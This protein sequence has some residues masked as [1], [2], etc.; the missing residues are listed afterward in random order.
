NR[1][2]A[3]QRYTLSLHDALPILS[4]PVRAQ[5]LQGAPVAEVAFRLVRRLRHAKQHP[6]LVLGPSPPPSPCRRQCQR[7]LLSESRP[8]VFAR[9]EEHTSELQSRENLVCRLL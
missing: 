8:V 7:P 1:P 2:S 4:S 6:R 3:L 5:H 9:S